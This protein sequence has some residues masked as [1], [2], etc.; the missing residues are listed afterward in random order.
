MEPNQR[1]MEIARNI[2]SNKSD[3]PK[4]IAAYRIE[5]ERDLTAILEVC[6]IMNNRLDK[7]FDNIERVKTS[8]SLI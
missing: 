2:L 8:D 7:L 6:G 1:D 4:A 3:V 5:I